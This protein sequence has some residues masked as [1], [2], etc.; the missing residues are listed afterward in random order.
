[1]EKKILVVIDMINDFVKEGGALYFPEGEAIIPAIK[2]KLDEARANGNPV[3]FVK[4]THWKNDKEFDR[5]PPHAMIG[6]E[7]G[8]IINEL[9]PNRNTEPVVFK[10]RFDGFYN[11]TLEIEL[12]RFDPNSTIEIVG[13][14]TSICIM[15]TAG[16][17]VDRDY[18]VEVPADCVADFDPDE[19]T[20]A[21]NRMQNVYGIKIT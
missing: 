11:T 12:E 2:K 19:H 15:E 14:C 4:D 3:I 5:F 18:K 10:T 8:Y 6:T 17:F 21:L 20:G 13:V 16:S 1:M 7:G 9:E